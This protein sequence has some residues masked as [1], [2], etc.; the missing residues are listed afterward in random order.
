MQ[1][2]SSVLQLDGWAA[3]DMLISK[4]TGLC[5]NWE[6]IVPRGSDSKANA[7]RY[8]EAIERLVELLD[9]VKRYGEL[10]NAKTDGTDSD[11]VDKAPPTDIRLESLL[12]VISGERPVF[13][14]ADRQASIESA[15]RFFTAR[16]IPI[17]ICGGADAMLC[18]DSLTEH[19][20]PVILVATYRVP[21]RR[22]DAYD[23]MYTLPAQLHKAGVRFAITGEGSGYPGGASNVRNLPYHAGAAVA[24]GLPRE[25]AVVAMTGSPAKILGI[26]HRVGTLAEDHHATLIVTDGDVLEPETQ[27]LEAYVEGR[28]V[29]LNSR[30]TQLYKKYQQK[31]P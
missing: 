13:V 11:L 7:E 6:S 1:G 23:A 26:D 10:I 27:I 31:L 16:Q 20:I 25:Q 3:E 8:D 9:Q 18:V 21:R 29:D 24:Y 28:R 12:P 15:I 30:H 2:Q 5:L 4:S 22:H 19:D 14:Q 17:V